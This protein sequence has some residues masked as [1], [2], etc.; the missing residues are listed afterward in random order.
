MET[1]VASYEHILRVVG[2]F[3]V[4]SCGFTDE[5]DGFRGEIGNRIAFRW[6][7]YAADVVGA[8][9]EGI[10]VHNCV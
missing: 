6:C 5:F 9:D 7:G 10:D 2:A 1:V 3:H 8:E 4:G